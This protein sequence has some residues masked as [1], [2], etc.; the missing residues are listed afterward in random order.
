MKKNIVPVDF[1]E[2]SEYALMAAAKM[3]K[4]DESEII[5]LH[6]L[7]LSDSHFSASDSDHLQELFFYLQL[8]ENRFTEFLKKP[9]LKG[10][11]V[12]PLVKHFK[13]FQ[14]VNDVAESHCADMIIM[15]S[16]GVSGAKEFLLGSNTE[17]VIRHA[18]IP[19]SACY[20]P[21]EIFLSLVAHNSDFS[22]DLLRRFSEELIEADN[23]IVSLGQK[24]LSQR[25]ASIL[26]HLKRQIGL[27]SEGY[28]AVQLSRSDYANIIG[29]AT[30]SVIRVLAQFKKTGLIS[31]QDRNIKIK[32]VAGLEAISSSVIQ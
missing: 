5:A 31:I 24:S 16:H 25:M 23:S 19:V 21:N 15:G 4:G 20:I 30:E 14:E 1:S 27:N 8:A 32:N 7:E 6:M 9:Y 18:E 2:H 11:T 29:A 22:H 13:V 26:L 3:A 17:K 28:I 12:I 10:I